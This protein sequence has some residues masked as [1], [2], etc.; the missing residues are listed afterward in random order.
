[1]H[2]CARSQRRNV[3]EIAEYERHMNI[4]VHVKNPLRKVQHIVNTLCDVTT[5]YSKFTTP[6]TIGL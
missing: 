1:M 6:Y 2:L 4:A 3:T 5:P